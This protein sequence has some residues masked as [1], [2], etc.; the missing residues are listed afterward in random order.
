MECVEF[1]ERG[2]CSTRGCRLPHVLRRRNGEG[3]GE[4]GDDEEDGDAESG[5]KEGEI[6]W[7]AKGKRRAA[8]DDG[9]E[10]EGGKQQWEGIS[11]AAGRRFKK[12]KQDTASLADNQDF[13]TISIPY[14]DDEEFDDEEEAEDDEEFDEDGEDV[15]SGSEEDNDSDD[16]E[17]RPSPPLKDTSIASTIVL[18]EPVEVTAAR[19]ES[20]ESGD[21]D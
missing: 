18:D 10:G 19:S 3:E 7:D 12:S 17:E 16:S 14:S 4:D 13:V 9:E 21:D 11:G 15:S 5:L 2:T 20:K 8:P 6:D 1:S